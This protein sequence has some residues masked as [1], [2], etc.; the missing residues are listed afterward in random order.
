MLGRY[1]HAGRAGTRTANFGRDA[2]QNGARRAQRTRRLPSFDPAKQPATPPTGGHA[3]R[4]VKRWKPSTMRTARSASGETGSASCAAVVS[5]QRRVASALLAQTLRF[6]RIRHCRRDGSR[7]RVLR[8]PVQEALV[9][10]RPS[11]PNTNGISPNYCAHLSS[12][13][14]RGRGPAS[15]FDS[16]RRGSCPRRRLADPASTANTA[17]AAG[18]PLPTERRQ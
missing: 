6:E 8:R 7:R 3:P 17:L 14:T 13:A 5:G 2:A 12:A 4:L 1:G 9:A 18:Q 10:L 16:R 15:S 11:S